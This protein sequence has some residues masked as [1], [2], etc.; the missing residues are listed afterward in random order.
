MTKLEKKIIMLL[1]DYPEQEF[2]SQE[3]ADKV[4]GSKASASGLL[5]VL[6]RQGV[7]FRKVKGRM[8]FYQ[9]NS[10][11]LEFKK[12]RIN[13]AIE[14][15]NL[16]LPE[17]KKL[18]QKIILF[19]SA[20]RGEQTSGSDLDLFILSRDKS[21]IKAVLKNLSVGWRLKPIIKTPGEWSELEITE[22]EF[23]QEIKNGIIL[24]DNDKFKN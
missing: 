20:S 16:L 8:K 7:V 19:G 13:S 6:S 2:Y 4:K 23:Y 9:I 10:K 12:L 3:I 18:S 5:K 17:L 15:I 1:A 24:Y 11:S 22:P 14:R 21:A